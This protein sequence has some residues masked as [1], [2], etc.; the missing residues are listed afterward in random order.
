MVVSDDELPDR[1]MD[2]LHTLYADRQKYISAMEKS[3]QMNAIPVIL[4]LIKEA[5][6]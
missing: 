6:R 2:A 4:N 5:S 1:I 3:S